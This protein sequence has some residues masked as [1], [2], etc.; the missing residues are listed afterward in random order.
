MEL[1]LLEK[2]SHLPKVEHPS[3]KG[4]DDAN[5]YYDFLY[6][7]AREVSPKYIVELGTNWGDSACRFA[8]GAPEAKV[9]TIDITYSP[10]QTETCKLFPNIEIWTENTNDLSLPAKL[11]KNGE[12][13]IL[14]IDTEH[15]LPQ[16]WGEYLN[17]G[18]LVKKGGIILYDDIELNDEMREFWKK[19][20]E[21]KI[22]LKH[23][24]WSGFGAS[25]QNTK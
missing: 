18:S 17:Y 2:L 16:A 10:V 20:P 25:I 15:N 23:L 6:Y 12:I 24:H 4:R 7:V 9:V 22:A 13:D 21:P 3:L 1:N 14:F 8:Y 5:P 19:I 11:A